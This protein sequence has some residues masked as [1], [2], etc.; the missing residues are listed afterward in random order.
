M[1]NKIKARRQSYFI[2]FNFLFCVH[3]FVLFPFFPSRFC[4]LCFSAFCSFP[5]KEK[6]IKQREEK[7]RERKRTKE[8]RDVNRPFP[9]LYFYV[10][11][12]K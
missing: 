3:R 1:A 4:F 7:E 12:L 6:Q 11:L 9:I 8:K 5:P 2:Y 10:Y